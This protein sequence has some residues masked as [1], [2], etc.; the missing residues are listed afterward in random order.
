[1]GLRSMAP[2]LSRLPILQLATLRK[3]TKSHV[4]FSIR[5]PLY[6]VA[7]YMPRLSI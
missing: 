1:M 5:L 7:S 3:M 2:I 4:L 6:A